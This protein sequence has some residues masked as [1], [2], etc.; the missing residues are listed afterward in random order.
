MASILI[1]Y[2]LEFV[3]FFGCEANLKMY[4]SCTH[5]VLSDIAVLK[6]LK[7]H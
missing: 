4:Y 6:V 7:S 2:E 5:E 1:Y 3:F